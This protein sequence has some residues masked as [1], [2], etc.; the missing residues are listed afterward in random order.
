MSNIIQLT[1]NKWVSE[2]V[3]IAVTG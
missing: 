2:K 3:L 1:P